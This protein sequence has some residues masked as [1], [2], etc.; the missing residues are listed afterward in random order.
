MCP[1][2]NDGAVLRRTV[3]DL[4]GLRHGL[5][6]IGIVPVGL[7]KYHR[8]GLRPVTPEDAEQ[9]CAYADGVGEKHLTRYGTRMVYVADELLLRAG[10]RIP[11]ARYYEGYPQ[12]ENGIGLLRLMLDEWRKVGRGLSG[13]TCG[14]KRRYLAAASVSAAPFVRRIADG[15]TKRIE[16]MTCEVLAIHNGFFGEQVTVAGLLTARDVIRVVR[17]RAPSGRTTLI[18]PAVMFNRAGHTLDGYS[19]KRLERAVGVPVIVVDS[20]SGLAEVVIS[21][22]AG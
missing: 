3:R 7:T 10:R 14:H 11:P 8:N 1:G 18:V 21:G 12:L 2:L 17:T 20:V 19:A 15:L 13:G 22:R 16:G 4:L 9:V 6:S 5:L